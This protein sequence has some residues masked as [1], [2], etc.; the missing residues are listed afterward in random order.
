MGRVINRILVYSL[1]FMMMAGGA[2]TNAYGQSPDGA[3]DKGGP[4]EMMVDMT[5]KLMPMKENGRAPETDRLL[6]DDIL[7]RQQDSIEQSK[8]DRF[9]VKYKE[10]GE[11]SFKEKNRGEIKDA[12]DIKETVGEIGF[13]KKNEAKTELLIL[14]EKVNPAD[15]AEVLRERN[16]ENDIEYIQ[17]DFQM[18]LNSPEDLLIETE[19]STT[20][21]A[22]T[23]EPAGEPASDGITAEEAI[24]TESAITT[25][26]AI[27]KDL[28]PEESQNKVIVAI[29]DTGLDITH[30]DL[31]E[32]IYVNQNETPD[33][34]ADDD[35]NGYADDISGWSFPDNSG[36]V[37]DETL[38]LEQSHGTHI[39]GIIA[40]V[41]NADENLLPNENIEIMPL[42]V[43]SN[44]VA[45]TSDIIAAIEYAR[46][47]GAKIVNCSFGSTYNNP[48]LEEA[49]ENTGMLFVCS[50]GNARINLEI[51]PVFPAC[52]DL[53]NIISV[54]SSN[55]DGGLSYFS[56][57]SPDLVDAAASGRNI[58]STLPNREYGPQSGTSM[59][60]ALVSGIAAAVLIE[61]NKQDSADLKQRLLDTSDKLSNLRNTV[62]EGR[63]INAADAIAGRVKTD[64]IQNSPESDFDVK[65]YNPT[66][67][68]L[69]QLYSS[70]TV[71]EV[72]AGEGT[73][74]ILKNDGTV[75][76]WGSN[77]YG[78]CGNGSA[79]RSVILT[80][81]IGLT[82]I[83]GIA[84]GGSHCLAVKSDGTV[85]AW[86]LNSTGQ[87]GDGTTTERTIP[88]QVSGLTD[89]TG[90]SAGN[91]H[92]LAL[93]T[94]GT[95]WAWGNNS[96]GH[97]GD[98]TTVSTTTPVQTS[99]LTGVVSIAAGDSHSLAAKSNGTAWS[100]GRNN[101][102][103][104]GDGTTTNKTAPVQ[105][106][107]LTGVAS[108]GAGYYHS[109]AVKTDGTAWACGYNLRGQLGDGTTT[110]R[111]A[112][113]QVSGLTG[114]IRADA[115]YRHSIVMK[116][117]GTAWAW[118][119]NGDGQL[120]D[121]TTVNKTTPVRVSGLTGVTGIAA[122][123]E[124]SLALKSGGTVWA[125]GSNTDGQLGDGNPVIRVAPQ[126]INTLSDVSGVAAGDYCSLSIKSGGTAW[127]W[128]DNEVG[129]L[130]DGTTTGRTT[131]VQVSNITTAAVIAGKYDHGLAVKTDGTVWAW[132]Y[133]SDGQLGDGTTDDKT[134]PVQVSGLTGA[135]SAAAGEAHS[136][137][138]KSD[139]TVWAWGYNSNGQLGDGT[140]TDR[141]SPVRA[142]SLTGVVRIAAG[143]S[144]SLA[145][146]SDGTVWAWGR[147]TYGQLGDGTTTERTSPVQVSGLTG[148]VDVAAGYRYSLAVKSDGT[149]WTWGRNNY[150][151]L[152]DGT[153][154]NR[155]TPG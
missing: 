55:A 122:G 148:V 142:G 144:H 44:G 68:E 32:Y 118:G 1:V 73:S 102:G 100:W 106:S 95:V 36:A 135:V 18:E 11:N 8:T 79:I 51:A 70:G 16:A 99:G 131:P 33:N 119:D 138:L 121:G 20:E 152:G 154:A 46:E 57:Y 88:V 27:L 117:D 26:E 24:T 6:L 130:G 139:G 113:V 141:T 109:I 134:V 137:A 4:F 60:A 147:N 23:E 145:V 150:G 74:L 151:Q 124:Y 111:T 146:K 34:G 39:A 82:D 128:G 3:K 47:M 75:W 53:D 77:S 84:A 41:S 10:G 120:G 56:N 48:A 76:A 15:F 13:L 71:A 155:S 81:V 89:V 129:Q 5:P 30:P 78:Q 19:E 7:E 149:V 12:F 126:R 64:I 63:R 42:K 105:M 45:Y 112:P 86:G 59:S 58:N 14:N 25:E 66:Q 132:G 87:L 108:V 35:G 62:S 103:Q 31:E 136:L 54:T 9:I 49:M 28:P 90:V 94:D 153:T 50:A 98:G 92:S 140:S 93:K 80:Q 83:T 38:G 21:G 22:I 114:A 110:N 101:Y 85:W 123:F 65:G 43:F 97:L 67:R 127:S 61:D 91:S 104:L 37:Y 52:F 107:G 72:A 116:S 40:G 29:I 96:Y 17:P 2:A 69:Y 115:G 133:N 143:D 125:W